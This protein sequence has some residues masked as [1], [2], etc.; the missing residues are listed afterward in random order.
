MQALSL[1]PSDVTT[2]TGEISQRSERL[3]PLFAR[4]NP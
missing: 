2:L 1:D 3:K 4:V